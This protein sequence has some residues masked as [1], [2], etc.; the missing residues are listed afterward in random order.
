MLTQ[1]RL[2]E[3]YRLEGNDFIGIKA[4]RKGFGKV[5][6]CISDG[7]VR[8]VIDGKAYAKDKLIVLYKTGSLPS[9]EKQKCSAQLEAERAEMFNSLVTRAW[10]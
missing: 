7:Y 3:L 1:A 6:G 2:K 8:I 9:H 5:A 10:V 4:G